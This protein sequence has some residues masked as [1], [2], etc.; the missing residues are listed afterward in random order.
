V[1]MCVCVVRLETKVVKFENYTCTPARA[2][3]QT[4]THTHTHTHA[5]TNTHNAAV[6]R[7][8]ASATFNMMVC[9]KC[10]CV[11]LRACVGALYLF[12]YT[13]LQTGMH[14]CTP[15]HASKHVSAHTTYI[16]PDNRQLDVCLTTTIILVC[17]RVH[18]SER[19]WAT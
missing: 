2:R 14:A 8:F 13:C 19:F 15:T 16:L 3:A 17:V 7:I 11:R 10:L 9:L 18:F 5:Q 1:L 12:V 6:C 4:H